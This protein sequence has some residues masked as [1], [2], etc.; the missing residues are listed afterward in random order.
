MRDDKEGDR[1]LPTDTYETNEL[2]TE[3]FSLQEAMIKVGGFGKHSIVRVV[4][5][6]VPA[7]MHADNDPWI[8]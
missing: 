8:H 2:S 6:Q 3:R 1:I 5:R 4:S 7:D